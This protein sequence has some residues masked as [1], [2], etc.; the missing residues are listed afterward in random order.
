MFLAIS[1]LKLLEFQTIP[2]M[3]I[4]YHVKQLQ[5]AAALQTPTGSWQHEMVHLQHVVFLFPQNSVTTMKVN[6][7]QFSIFWKSLL[8]LSQKICWLKGRF[9]F[10]KIFFFS[11]I[12]F[13]LV[14]TESQKCRNSQEFGI[15]NCDIWI[16]IRGKKKKIGSCVLYKLFLLRAAVLSISTTRREQWTS[17]VV[18]GLW[19]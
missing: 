6:L 16:Y 4:K 3:N 8:I 19:T 13:I 7:T 5:W 17:L 10:F 1:Y 2:A 9:K 15:Y 11:D 18:H 12:L 14:Y